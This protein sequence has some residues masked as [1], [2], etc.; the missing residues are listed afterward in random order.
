MENVQQCRSVTRR[1]IQVG[2]L[3]W[4]LHVISMESVYF[5]C[6]IIIPSLRE[7]AFFVGPARTNRHTAALHHVLW[8]I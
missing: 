6:V 4:L 5:C 2:R 1:F 8:S 7:T 3:D